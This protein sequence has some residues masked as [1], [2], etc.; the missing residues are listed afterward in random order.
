MNT[1]NQNEQP[2]I[3]QAMETT[4]MEDRSLPASQALREQQ[5]DSAAKETAPVF[6]P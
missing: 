6:I 2:V 4:P 3:L 5:A 1:L